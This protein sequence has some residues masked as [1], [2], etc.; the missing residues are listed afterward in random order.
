MLRRIPCVL[1]RGGSSEGLFFLASDL[2]ADV[3][4]RDRVLLAAMGSP[5]LRQIDGLGGGD[6]Q[7]SKVVLVSPSERP[8]TDAEYRFAQVSV[9]RDIVDTASRRLRDR[10]PTASR[11]QSII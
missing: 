9:P 5:D 10:C 11:Q 7:T 3:A 6:D 4:T 8:D 1:M 2:P